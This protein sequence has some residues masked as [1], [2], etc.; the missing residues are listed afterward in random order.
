MARK[1]PVSAA[2]EVVYTR[3]AHDDCGISA[4]CKINTPPG[5]ANLCW[6]HYDEHFAKQALDNL[7]KWGLEKLPGEK[8]PEHTLRMRQFFRETA[9]QLVGR[10]L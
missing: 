3:C 2:Q 4:F 10:V 6:Q 8:A 7:P 5:W 9:M 1:A